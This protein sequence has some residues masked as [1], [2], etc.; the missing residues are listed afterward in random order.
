MLE[1]QWK[2]NYE[3]EFLRPLASWIFLVAKL[4]LLIF[5]YQWSHVVNVGNI[6]RT[7]LQHVPRHK[8]CGQP[9]WSRLLSSAWHHHCTFIYLFIYVFIYLLIYLCIYLFIY[10]FIYLLFIYSWQWLI[11][12]YNRF[13]F[14]K[15][16]LAFTIV[17]CKA[18]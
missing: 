2:N 14:S 6:I 10:L 7:Y 17:F 11:I 16:R 1:H 5:L 15:K 8:F 13:L 9:I 4:C 3:E 12:Y 18:N